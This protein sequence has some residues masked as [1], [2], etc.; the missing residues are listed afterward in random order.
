[1]KDG[2]RW[3]A[4]HEEFE[5]EATKSKVDLSS[6]LFGLGYDIPTDGT[7]VTMTHIE[8]GFRSFLPF[9]LQLWV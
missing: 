4:D 9:Y 7:Q 5:S 3:L 6:W 8:N 1:M 2:S